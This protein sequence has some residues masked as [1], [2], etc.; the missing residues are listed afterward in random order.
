MI[1]ETAGARGRTSAPVTLLIGLVAVAGIAIRLVAI[2]EPLGIDQSLWASA[3]RGMAHGQR[4]YHDVWEQRPPGFTGSISPASAFSAGRPPRSRGSTFSR[5]RRRAFCS[6]RLSASQQRAN[7]NDRRGAL[8]LADRCRRGCTVTAD[9]SSGVSARPSSCSPSHSPPGASFASGRGV[10][11]TAALGMGLAAGA[12][13]VLKPNAGCTFPHCCCGQPSHARRRRRAPTACGGGRGSGHP[14]GRGVDLAVAVS[15]CFTMHGS[16][17]STSTASTLARDSAP[18]P[19]RSILRKPCGSGQDRS[20]VALWHHR[21]V[22]RAGGSGTTAEDRR[23]LP[24]LAMVGVP[25]RRGHR[26]QRRPSVQQLLHQCTSAPCCSWRHGCWATDGDVAGAGRHCGGHDRADDRVAG[27][28]G[29]CRSCFGMDRTRLACAR[30]EVR[31]RG[32]P[33]RIWRV[34][35]RSRL[36]RAGER[37]A[38]P[39][40]CATIRCPTNGSCAVRD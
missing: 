23:P 33:R 19:M 6:P 36:Q 18:P 31:S 32:V 7:R 4:L 9:S 16:R 39:P 25:R 37:G 14:A 11:V 24:A 22:R 20:A 1:S 30:G 35:E 38:R 21:L 10:R 29:L 27:A 26:G 40:T 17:S 15:T 2:A 3:V 34:C 12:A 5:P 8:R 13:V 28:S